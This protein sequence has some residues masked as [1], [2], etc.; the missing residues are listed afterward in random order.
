MFEESPISRLVVPRM[1]A[2]LEDG[3]LDVVSFLSLF[4]KNGLVLASGLD[5]LYLISSEVPPI[6][7]SVLVLYLYFPCVVFHRDGIDDLSRLLVSIFKSLVVSQ[8][9]VETLGLSPDTVGDEVD[10]VLLDKFMVLLALVGAPSEFKV[11]TLPP[12]T[13]SEPFT[14]DS[15]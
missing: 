8:F 2:V 7:L 11:S 4:K 15:T 9:K 13:F 3:C 5:P 1:E 10:T 6:L 14:A 12:V